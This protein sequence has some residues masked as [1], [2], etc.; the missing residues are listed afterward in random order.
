MTTP[1]SPDL[2][3]AKVVHVSTNDHQ[4]TI[5]RGAEHGVKLGYRY[6]VYELGEQITD[7]DTFETLGRLEV[8]KGTGVVI[9]VQEKMATLQS[10]RSA[11]AGSVRIVHKTH[12]ALRGFTSM[13]GEDEEHQNLPP[14][15]IPFESPHTGD[16]AK[17]L[18]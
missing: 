11:K 8:V 5:N 3:P 12:P 13:F 18:P 10:D 4:V 2:T 6:L 7:P 17:R 16:Y 15:E 14:K 9:H 1:A